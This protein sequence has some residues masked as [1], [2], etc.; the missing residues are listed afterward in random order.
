MAARLG[1]EKQF[2]QLPRGNLRWGPGRRDSHSL[3]SQV[4]TKHYG[5][6]R[7][8]YV[9]VGVGKGLGGNRAGGRWRR[10]RSEWI[11]VDY[12]RK[13]QHTVPQKKGQKEGKT[14]HATLPPPR[15]CRTVGE[16]HKDNKVKLKGIFW[17]VL[18]GTDLAVWGIAEQLP[19]RILHGARD[20]AVHQA[21]H[22]QLRNAQLPFQNCVLD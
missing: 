22:S 6:R 5:K 9:T 3:M 13:G 14:K 11:T 12:N 18:T 20:G 17:F 7:S 2:N 8:S 19:F 15:L 1:W 16:V 10:R 21:G 4:K